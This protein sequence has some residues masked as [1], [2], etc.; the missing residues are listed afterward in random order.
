MAVALLPTFGR[1]PGG[2][3]GG[4]AGR[5]MQAHLMSATSW[6]FMMRPA[7][8]QEPH[9]RLG[10]HTGFTLG[11]ITAGSVATFA[12]YLG[13]AGLPHPLALGL[14]FLNAAFF[15]VLLADSRS[16]QALL[17]VG[18]GAVLCI[19]AHAVLPEASL[20]IAG[21]AGGSIAFVLGGR[22]RR[23]P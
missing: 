14:L 18:L 7:V 23:A 19:P 6:A 9:R 22:L 17:A 5:L 8:P 2:I 11:C 21:M 3:P 15:M 4:L 13:A 12:G 16:G 1:P 20:L 10:Y